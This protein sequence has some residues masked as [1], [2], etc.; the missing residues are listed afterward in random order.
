MIA[1]TWRGRA[2]LQSS[3]AYPTHFSD[4][5]LPA[6]RR[7]DGFLGAHLLRQEHADHVEFQVLTFWQS[8]DAIRTFAGD[9]YRKAVVEPEAAAALV[10][11][12]TTVEHYEVMLTWINSTAS[13][14]STRSS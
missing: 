12:D 9:D 10:S 8:L 13:S 14:R 2:A 3:D 1:R 4:A 6:L 7:I 11:Y 5:V